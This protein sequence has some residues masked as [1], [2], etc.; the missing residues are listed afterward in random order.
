[1]LANQSSPWNM[2]EQD[3]PGRLSENQRPS[4]G[5]PPRHGGERMPLGSIPQNLAT[6]SSQSTMGVLESHDQTTSPKTVSQDGC[7][8]KHVEGQ[9]ISCVS[10]GNNDLSINQLTLNMSQSSIP[11][12]YAFCDPYYGGML[13]AYG[14]PVQQQM[15][16]MGPGRVPLPIEIAEDGPIYVNSKQYHAILRRRQMRAKLEAQNKLIKSRKPYLH[17]S[18][19]QHA[20]NRVRGSGGRFLSSKKTQQSQSTKPDS[21]HFHQQEEPS[22]GDEHRLEAVELDAPSLMQCS[23][24]SNPNTDISFQRL[25]HRLPN[26]TSRLAVSLPGR[27]THT[28]DMEHRGAPVVR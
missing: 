10:V 28:C 6:S 13:T 7:N 14:L 1:M 12:P 16:G 8:T 11:V 4:T 25:D 9:P 24:S 18:R 2:R 21:D 23:S 19:H 27:T 15:V 22:E 3:S 5:T 26:M 17:E 20:V